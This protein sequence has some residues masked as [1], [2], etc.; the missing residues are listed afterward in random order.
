MMKKFCLFFIRI[1]KILIKISYKNY[2][3][4]REVINDFKKEIIMNIS[5]NSNKI[6]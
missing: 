2:N 6:R 4:I 1:K 5:C 3:D